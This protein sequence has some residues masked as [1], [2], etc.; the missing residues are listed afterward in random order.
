MVATLEPIKTRYKGYSF[1]SRT[2][3][4]YA[5]AFD[6]IGVPW[7]YE[8]QGF[9]LGDGVRYLPDFWMPSLDLYIEVK[10]RLSWKQQTIYM[11]GTC[12]YG[13]R[14]GLNMY[15]HLAAGP[16]RKMRHDDNCENV[17]DYSLSE[18]C[19]SDRVVAW[20][21]R[22]DCYGTLV[23]IGIAT[24]RLVPVTIGFLNG[25]KEQSGRSNVYDQN[26]EMAHNLWFA[27]ACCASSMECDSPQE[28]LDHLV[29]SKILEPIPDELVKAQK[30]AV[31]SHKDVWIV[32]SPELSD[33]TR[34]EVTRLQA[35][36][37]SP[38]GCIN[39]FPLFKIFDKAKAGNLESGW[40]ES[41]FRA[42]RSSRFEHG[43]SG[44]T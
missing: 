31:A 30:L 40:L 38:W 18:L 13:W 24:G 27:E 8:V 23:E 26:W 15:G 20:I 21:D 32:T 41:A 43:E 37:V 28:I 19:E 33:V 36:R 12:E 42:Y 44:A 9:D 7:E 29:A 39:R 22:C 16:S 17:F 10:P 5:V 34:T 35:T 3:A 6:S 25:V 2:E 4:R 14:F 1:R 11:A